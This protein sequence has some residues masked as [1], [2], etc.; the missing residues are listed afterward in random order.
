M[1]FGWGTTG[2]EATTALAQHIKGKTV[3]VTGVSPGGLGLETARVIALRNPKL[4]ILAGRSKEKLEQAEAE[5]NKAAPGTAVRQL[6]L[7]LGDLKKVRSAAA[8]VNGWEDVPS[9]DVVVNNAGIMA[10]PFA[11]TGDGIEK[12]FGTNHIGH[13]LF[14]QLVM[15]KILESQ[16]P[17]V[18]SFILISLLGVVCFR[19]GYLYANH[20]VGQFIEQWV[21]GWTC[22]F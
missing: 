22:P 3:I 6:V 15:G 9:I 13:F 8:E 5:V 4:I 17:R 11:L 20:C 16:S 1:V 7:D 10:T 2:E 19:M 12:Q 14:T 21:Q 18:V